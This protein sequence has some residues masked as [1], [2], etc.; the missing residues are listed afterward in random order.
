M[1]NALKIDIELLV[2]PTQPEMHGGRV[3]LLHHAKA[4][5]LHFR[6]GHEAVVDRPRST[7]AG[8]NAPVILQVHAHEAGELVV[9]LAVLAVER[10]GAERSKAHPF[11]PPGLPP[12]RLHIPD[13]AVGNV[14]RTSTCRPQIV[15]ESNPTAGLLVLNMAVDAE[16]RRL[17]HDAGTDLEQIGFAAAPAPSS[18]HIVIETVALD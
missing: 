14:R 3:D 12:E 6:A 9:I 13:I 10:G 15:E 16:T 8:T 17:V 4:P 5:T 18:S 2:L 7:Q 11:G 1:S